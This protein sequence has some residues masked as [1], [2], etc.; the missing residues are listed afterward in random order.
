LPGKSAGNSRGAVGQ[1]SP[2]LP[3]IRAALVGIAPAQRSPA[4][5]A[6]RAALLA[7]APATLHGVLRCCG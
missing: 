3:T 1:H 7:N 5:P 6:I 2:A 4:L